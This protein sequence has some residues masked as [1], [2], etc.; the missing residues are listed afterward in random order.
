DPLLASEEFT[1]GGPSYG[2]AYDS[3]EITGDHGAA[4]KLELR[5]GETTNSAYLQSYQG[6]VFYDAGAVWNRDA[7]GGEPEKQTLTSTGVGVRL[8][9]SRSLFGSAEIAFPLSRD[10]ASEGND[11]EDPRLFFNILKRF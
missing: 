4:L 10:I 6:Y 8:N 2:R 11:G 5:Y 7:A 1:I 3:S 9:M